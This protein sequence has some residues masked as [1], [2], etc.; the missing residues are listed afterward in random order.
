MSL[1]H[2]SWAFILALAW[3]QPAQAQFIRGDVTGDGLVNIVDGIAELDCL[4]LGG[5]C[6]TC[7]DAADVDDDG[8]LTI[9]DPIF[10]LMFLFLGGA[11]PPPPSVPTGTACGL[12]PTPDGLGCAA[13]LPCP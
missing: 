7:D 13:Y 6:P 12:D 2:F 11:V 4:F 1:K 8:V 10:N 9:V 3:F 5:A